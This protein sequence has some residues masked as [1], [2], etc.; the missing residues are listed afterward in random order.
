MPGVRSCYAFGDS[1]HLTIDH[2]VLQPGEL[3]QQLIHEGHTDIEIREIEATI[4]DCFMEI[5]RTNQQP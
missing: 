4:E 1:H 2:N 5:T 3:T